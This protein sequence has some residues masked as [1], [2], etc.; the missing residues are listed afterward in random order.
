MQP[1]KFVHFTN[2]EEK[3]S[4][5]CECLPVRELLVAV[6][7][8][9]VGTHFCDMDTTNLRRV[10]NYFRNNGQSNFQNSEILN[11][12]IMRFMSQEKDQVQVVIEVGNRKFY[13]TKSTL[14]QIPYFR[15]LYN[16]QGESTENI[17][18]DPE[19]FK[20]ILSHVRNPIEYPLCQMN[21]MSL[22]L[23]Y[24]G[25]EQGDRSIKLSH[26]TYPN[27]SLACYPYL[28]N[29]NPQITF[30][31]SVWKRSTHSHM[32]IITN[33]AICSPSLNDLE[34]ER[35]I[36]FESDKKWQM[37][38]MLNDMYLL[39][40]TTNKTERLS[41][42]FSRIRITITANDAG[43]CNLTQSAEVMEI[44]S[45]LKY[46]SPMIIHE[47]NCVDPETG[48][49]IKYV[50][51]PLRFYFCNNIGHSFPM[52]GNSKTLKLQVFGCN[53][54]DVKLRSV[55]YMLEKDERKA[56]CRDLEILV[57]TQ[58]KILAEPVINGT[59][60]KRLEVKKAHAIRYIVFTVTDKNNERVKCDLHGYIQVDHNKY[61]IDPHMNHM[62]QHRHMRE[63][64]LG[65]FD[66]Q[67]YTDPS[68]LFS[69]EGQLNIGG[70]GGLYN[71]YIWI[72]SSAIG[73]LM[74]DT[75]TGAIYCKGD[76]EIQLECS[77]LNNVTINCWID[78]YDIF[79]INGQFF[80]F[81]YDNGE[82]Y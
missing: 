82:E 17:D 21:D 40:R 77:I 64:S 44:I 81:P 15:G 11:Y 45:E 61:M 29:M 30:F 26:E 75:P 52:I 68:P 4:I 36:Y 69:I 14:L 42:L 65:M 78:E 60:N 48:H 76:I 31:A 24:W 54:S 50:T 80:G 39:I 6:A 79:R 23:Q 73:N 53:E 19:L 28:L 10:L 62:H 33:D 25:Y 66:I 57:N 43:S 35:S 18:R 16:M 58:H 38:D 63:N 20:R 3:Y 7:Q 22:E 70:S 34:E 13:T 37:S 74:C 47:S 12:D 51:V 27:I 71:P 2:G 72:V 55:A 59:I 8:P 49:R 5:A 1:D 41:D 32:N 9:N 46:E 67:K 56:K